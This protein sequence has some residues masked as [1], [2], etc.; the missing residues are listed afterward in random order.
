LH[1]TAATKQKRRKGKEKPGEEKET[2]ERKGGKKLTEGESKTNKAVGRTK[3]LLS[4]HQLQELSPWCYNFRE[5][6]EGRG[7]IMGNDQPRM[8]GPRTTV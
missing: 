6:E 4:R 5:W 2:K 3:V 1:A 8:S 7:D